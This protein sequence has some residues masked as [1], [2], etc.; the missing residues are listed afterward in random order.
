MKISE[1]RINYLS[2]V[3][4]ESLASKGLV[5]CSDVNSLSKETK[6]GVV[7]FVQHLEKIGEKV[8]SKIASIKRG[9]P[10]GSAEWEILYRQYY[11]EEIE[12]I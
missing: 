8:I 4:A 7:F 12:K 2:R 3:I 5:D 6:K 10:E 1:G 11:N 9:V